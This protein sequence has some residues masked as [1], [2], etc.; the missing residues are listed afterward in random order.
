VIVE[1]VGAAAGIVGV[2]RELEQL[3]RHLG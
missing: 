3:A 2:N 1:N